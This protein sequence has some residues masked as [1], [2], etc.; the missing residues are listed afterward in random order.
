MYEATISDITHGRSAGTL[1]NYA[2]LSFERD[3]GPIVFAG[4][5]RVSAGPYGIHLHP[6]EAKS[7]R[8]DSWNPAC[9]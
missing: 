6:P 3:A 9:P 1:A 2:T 8:E 5:T 7:F 4:R